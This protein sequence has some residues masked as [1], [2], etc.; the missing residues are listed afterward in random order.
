MAE[1]SN[2]CQR[3][4]F[5]HDDDYQYRCHCHVIQDNR[6]V[7]SYRS[8]CCSGFAQINV[9]EN[10]RQNK[11]IPDPDQQKTVSVNKLI[12]HNLSGK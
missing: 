7:S 8:V 10:F 12:G 6:V 9:T 1:S 2:F 3:Y 4:N 5:H 11:S